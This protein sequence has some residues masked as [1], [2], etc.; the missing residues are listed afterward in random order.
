MG[1]GVRLLP[2]WDEDL[3]AAVESG[4]AIPVRGGGA[5][6]APNAGDVVRGTMVGRSGEGVPERGTGAERGVGGTAPEDGKSACP[7]WGDVTG[8]ENGG[9]RFFGGAAACPGT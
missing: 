4:V 9:V 3:I 5:K 7:G 1:V 2:R 6:G 8:A